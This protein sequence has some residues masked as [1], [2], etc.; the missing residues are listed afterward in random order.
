MSEILKRIVVAGGLIVIA[1]IVALLQWKFGINAVRYVGMLVVA[2][3]IFEMVRCLFKTKLQVFVQDWNWLKFC[4]FLA[5]L[6]LM[7]FAV[8]N[9]SAHP[10]IILLLLMIICGADVGAWFFGKIVGGDKLWQKISA[11]KTWTGQIAGIVCGTLMSILYGFLF[12]GQFMPQL[13]WIG[14]SI[15]L[16]SQYGDLTASWIKR[17]MEIKD[18]GNLLPGHGGMLDRFDGWIYA[19]PLIWCVML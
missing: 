16:L 7:M 4:S 8:Y 14:I 9:V 5:L 18:F 15:S 13:L 3:M 1:L 11:N 2:I 10:L 17:K 12:A 19:L 6:V